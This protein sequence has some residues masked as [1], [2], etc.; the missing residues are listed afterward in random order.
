[1]LWVDQGCATHDVTEGHDSGRGRGKRV[2]RAGAPV[3]YAL[4]EG[5]AERAGARSQRL[6]LGGDVLG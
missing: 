1:M 2:R 5:A 4:L 3:V 6:L